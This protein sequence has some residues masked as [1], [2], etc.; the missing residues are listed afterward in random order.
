MHVQRQLFQEVAKAEEIAEEAFRHSGTPGYQILCRAMA[1]SSL[2]IPRLRPNGSS[3]ADCSEP[4]RPSFI[5]EPQ[6]IVGNGLM[7]LPL[8]LWVAV[9]PHDV[10]GLSNEKTNCAFGREPH[11]TKAAVH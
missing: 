2:R 7:C 10:V 4:T 6:G 1:H 8:E 9:V 3:R 11:G 5:H